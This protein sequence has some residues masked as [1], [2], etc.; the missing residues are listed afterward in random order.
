V[1]KYRTNPDNKLKETE[2][3]KVCNKKDYDAIEKVKQDNTT[4][5][6]LQSA[7]RNKLA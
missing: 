3:N 5:I 1:K 6:T 7:F 4:S 2:K